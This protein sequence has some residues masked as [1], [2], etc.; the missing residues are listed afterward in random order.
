M[1]NACEYI[2]ENLK[3]LDRIVTSKGCKTVI[4]LIN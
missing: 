3:L 4:A 2:K 1:C